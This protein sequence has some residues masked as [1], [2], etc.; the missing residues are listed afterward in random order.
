[1]PN[2]DNPT[3]RRIAVDLGQL[4]EDCYLAKTL[5][6]K[7]KERDAAIERMATVIEAL[8]A[9]GFEVDLWLGGLVG[10]MT[11]KAAMMFAGGEMRTALAKALEAVERAT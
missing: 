4:Y 2:T 11:Q 7:T 1:M 6:H 9:S 8:R 5:S 3:S 10:A